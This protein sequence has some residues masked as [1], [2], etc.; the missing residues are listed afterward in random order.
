MNWDLDGLSLN[1]VDVRGL[2]PLIFLVVFQLPDLGVTTA[3][4]FDNGGILESPQ[5][6]SPVLV[7]DESVWDIERFF[8]DNN[9]NLDLLTDLSFAV[10]T[11]AVDE[12][13]IGW[14]AEIQLIDASG[15]S[16]VSDFDV[17]LRVAQGLQC[18]LC[19]VLDLCGDLNGYI[20][21]VRR[22]LERYD[23]ILIVRELDVR[24]NLC[25]CRILDVV[26]SSYSHLRVLQ[27]L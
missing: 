21:E 12:V 17:G 15:V 22:H 19:H 2:R 1:Y 9:G 11:Q 27:Q 5:L 26:R 13:A 14:L 6:D 23:G 24:E 4:G 25:G 3:I 18:L 16:M 7:G 20:G 10:S 8:R